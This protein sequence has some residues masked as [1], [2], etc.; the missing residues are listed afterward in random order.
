[1]PGL[2]ANAKTS[3]RFAELPE[4]EIQRELGRLYL[5]EGKIPEGVQ[6]LLAYYEQ[7]SRPVYQD[8]DYLTVAGAL[9]TEA[10]AVARAVQGAFAAQAIGQFSNEQADRELTAL[11]D[12]SEALATLAEKMQVS[13]LLDPAHR[14]RVL[15]YNL[16]NQSD[17]EALMF[18]R[19]GDAERQRRA[20]L[21]RTAFWKS[22]D[23]AESLATGLLGGEPALPASESIGEG[24]PV[25]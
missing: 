9:D 10:E 11:H 4:D 18:T 22:R 20:D 19:T 7:P 5:A 8:E 14:Y 15:A 6:Y 3:V 17:F 1:L 21:L 23:Q 13:P 16:L 2:L 12:R 25:E 24:G